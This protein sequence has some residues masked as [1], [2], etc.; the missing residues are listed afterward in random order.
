MVSKDFFVQDERT[1]SQDSVQLDHDA[2]ELKHGTEQRQREGELR[3]GA[4]GAENL[5]TGDIMMMMIV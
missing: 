3:G 2:T 4:G 1:N 5:P